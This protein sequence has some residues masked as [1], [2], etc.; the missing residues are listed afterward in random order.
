M[1]FSANPKSWFIETVDDLAK[2]SPN[3]DPYNRAELIPLQIRASLPDNAPRLMN[4]HDMT[5]GFIPGGD[6]AP[7][8]THGT[9]YYNFSYWQYV[10]IL[11]YMF[12]GFLACPPPCWINA[13]HKNGVKVLGNITTRGETPGDSIV[14]PT[15]LAQSDFYIK[16]LGD[17]ANYYGF[18]GWAWNLEHP[19]PGAATATQLVAFLSKF[20]QQYPNLCTIFY[21]SLV[22]DG[23]CDWQNELNPKN[24]PFFDACHGIFLNYGWNSQNL[25]NSKALAR[26]RNRDVYV[27][28]QMDQEQI[29]N[30]YNA[31]LVPITNAEL[32]VGLYG[33][34]ALTYEVATDAEPADALERRLWVG[35]PPYNVNQPANSISKAISIRPCS[36]EL[37]V[38]SVFD[39]GKGRGLYI[40]GVQAEKCFNKPSELRWGN[41]SAQSLIP[42]MRLPVSWPNNQDPPLFKADFTF[43]WAWD[44]GS[45][46]RVW[47]DV[48]GSPG[49]NFSVID[50][51]PANTYF[52]TDTDSVVV[53]CKL[54]GNIQAPKIEVVLYARDGMSI[55][56]LITP[57]SDGKPQVLK[58][59]RPSELTITK[60]QIRCEATYKSSLLLGMLSLIKGPAKFTGSSVKN[61]NWINQSPAVTPTGNLLTSFD[62][63]WDAGAAGDRHYNVYYSNVKPSGSFD[64]CWFLGRSFVTRFYCDQFRFDK[65]TKEAYFVVQPMDKNGFTQPLTEC[66]ANVFAWKAPETSSQVK[67]TAG[68]I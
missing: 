56:A 44:G 41:M 61:I 40:D 6:Q 34:A 48:P 5:Q 15:M 25:A 62:L 11:A 21:D 28:I 1:V 55:S 35:N 67:E 63:I 38:I 27:G 49:N 54:D 4:W 64:S 16:Q 58:F 47:N 68:V 17:M 65:G 7:Q 33:P 26:D 53:S 32:S 60:I 3:Q 19:L 20:K 46:L 12:H 18:D 10:D 9:D 57:T 43:D 59:S 8:G 24:K 14:I 31:R 30:L 13:G 23:S 36:A 45:S 22:M 52:D 37:P 2:W 51:F 39:T 42:D 50:L 29:D 66:A